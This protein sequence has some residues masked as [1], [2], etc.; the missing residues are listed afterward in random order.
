MDG[1][2]LHIHTYVPAFHPS[3]IYIL[4]LGLIPFFTTSALVHCT[5]VPQYIFGKQ[6]QHSCGQITRVLLLP[7]SIFQN[8]GKTV[9]LPV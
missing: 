2:I 3:F 4:A 6:D 9:G 1:P 7:L 8:P 5:G